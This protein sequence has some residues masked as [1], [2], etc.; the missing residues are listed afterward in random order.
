MSGDYY[1][2]II[3]IGLDFH[4][5]FEIF[6]WFLKKLNLDQGRVHIF[7]KFVID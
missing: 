7:N 2:F 4:K 6:V 3:T 1:F 5:G